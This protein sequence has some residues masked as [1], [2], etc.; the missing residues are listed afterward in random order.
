MVAEHGGNSKE[1]SATNSQYVVTVE[2]PENV[3][4]VAIVTDEQGHHVS[5]LFALLF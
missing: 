3:E 2:N 5:N 1:T 4:A